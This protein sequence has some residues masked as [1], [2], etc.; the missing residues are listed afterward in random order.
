MKQSRPSRARGLTTAKGCMNWSD[1]SG[2]RVRSGGGAVLI[3]E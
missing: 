1:T 2:E 3:S